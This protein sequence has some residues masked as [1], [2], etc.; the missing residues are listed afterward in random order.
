MISGY[1]ECYGIVG[2]P[3]RQALSPIIHNGAFMAENRD[4]VFLG[5]E[6]DT[7]DLHKAVE[8][9]KALGIKGLVV[10]MPHK[11]HIIQYLDDVEDKAKQLGAVNLV[12]IEDGRLK[13]YNT[14]GDGF[15]RA[16]TAGNAEYTGKEIFLLGA[17]G[18]ARGIARS[19]L[20]RRISKL[21]VCNLYHQEAMEMIGDMKQYTNVPVVYVP[22]CKEEV[23]EAAAKV[24]LVINATSLGM[25]GNAADHIPLFDWNRMPSDVV[26]ADIVHSPLVTDFLKKATE[27]GHRV[28]TGD[29]MLLYQGILAYEILLKKKAPEEAMRYQLKQWLTN[30]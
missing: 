27:Y 5:F 17:G 4:A 7:E 16:L 6:V 15:V 9:I 23:M 24:K 29:E 10:T 14:D 2:K 21:Y 11:H 28:I 26:F 1:T 30:H 12:T 22:F 13:G 19:L 25:G 18:A 20:D 8:G 3:V